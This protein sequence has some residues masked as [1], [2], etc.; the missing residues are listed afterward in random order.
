MDKPSEV[1]PLASPPGVGTPAGDLSGRVLGDFRIL[2]GLGQGGMGQVYLAEQ[3]SL[4]RKVALK[5]LRTDLAA[6][7]AALERF[8]AEALAVAQATHA[9]IVQVYFIGE[10]DGLHFMALE[11]VVGKNLREH[12]ERKGSPEVL[13]ALSIM[14]QV[15][16]A[17]Q[18]AGELGIVHR[19]IKPENILLTRKGEVKVTDFG[20]SRC[21]AGDGQPLR[22]TQS[23]IT[24]GTP[25]YM[26]PEQVQGQPIDARTDIYSFGVTCY[27]MLAGHP[28]FSGDNPFEVALRH[29]NAQPEPLATVRPDLP[30]ELCMIVHKMMAKPPEQ[31][32]QSGQDLIKDLVRLRERLTLAGGPQHTQALSLDSAPALPTAPSTPVVG[33]PTS[34]PIPT[35]GRRRLWPAVLLSLGAA[36]A[37]GATA[38]WLWRHHEAVPPLPAPAPEDTAPSPEPFQSLARREQFLK[39]AVEQYANPGKDQKQVQLGLAHC[40]E[41][42]LFY[43]E[44]GRLRE[45]NEFFNRL[46]RPGQEVPPYRF[47]GQLGHATVLGLEDRAAESDDLFVDWLTRPAATG[48]LKNNVRMHEW[49]ARALDH[50]LANET[51]DHPF[52]SKLEPF[53]H[54]A[55]GPGPRGGDKMPAKR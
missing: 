18:R 43:L 15:A 33:T 3:L 53:R 1:T 55:G 39:E 8:K 32:Y 4:R 35:P 41:L 45:A 5:F 38:G 52:P 37:L 16:A 47:F 50:N 44:Q 13:Q 6:N 19:D 30:P 23:G 11:Y 21:L 51:P 2:R 17:L 20:L 10:C 34:G 24:M 49:V 29:V 7:A 25:L 36:L 46:V 42:G 26:S 48:F 31:R 9:N 12:L 54:P 22:L 27:H 40:Q 28:P 14:R